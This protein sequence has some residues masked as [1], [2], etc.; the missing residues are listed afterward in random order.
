MRVTIT[1][2]NGKMGKALLSYGISEQ[3]AGKCKVIAGITRANIDISNENKGSMSEQQNL[4]VPILNDVIK[5]IKDTDVIIDFSS[6][7]Y[8]LNLASLCAEYKKTLICGTTG[9]T[10]QQ[11]KQLNEYANQT[12]IFQSPNMSV[13]VNIMAALAGQ[14]A[15]MLDNNFDI[16][17]LE[18]HHKNKVDSPS[19][20]AFLLAETIAQKLKV[21]LSEKQVLSRVGHRVR[22]QGEIGIAAIRAGSIIGEHT[23]IFAGDD[24]VIEISHKSQNR[25]IYVKGAFS[26][27][28]FC[29]SINPGKL[30][31]MHDLLRLV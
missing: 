9:F 29:K 13:G 31:G 1:A 5:V 11:N 25:L 17:I 12:V 27:A 14:A 22:K 7:S 26:A 16:E 21:S 15:L 8:S 2:A 19:G 6:P 18:K 4:K 3:N 28:Y 24:E 30:Y 10:T 20:T 23:V